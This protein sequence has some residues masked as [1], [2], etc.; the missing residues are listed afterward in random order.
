MG[1]IEDSR[2]P[3]SLSIAKIL[4]EPSAGYDVLHR[5][6]AI[7]SLINWYCYFED[8][9][10]ER[11]GKLQTVVEGVQPNKSAIYVPDD[12]AS[13][14]A[15]FAAVTA[16][17]GRKYLRI[18][19]PDI[20]VRDGFV[21]GFTSQEYDEA[22]VPTPF[23]FGFPGRDLHFLLHEQLVTGRTDFS[24]I[25]EAYESVVVS[26]DIPVI[27]KP[28]IADR[29]N[30]VEL[31]ALGTTEQRGDL[32]IDSFTIYRVW[33]G[34]HLSQFGKDLQVYVSDH[35]VGNVRRVNN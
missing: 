35:A 28:L 26:G 3:Q 10:N 7:S 34:F 9:F 17:S 21:C 32:K 6:W 19:S 12:A 18:S 4:K 5:D 20:E 1:Y 30:R 33:P 23:Y 22:I 14:E 15:H 25:S 24:Q 27:T 11:W 8:E 2:R 31:F 29:A 16:P 13:D